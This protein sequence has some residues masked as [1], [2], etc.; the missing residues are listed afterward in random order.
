[1]AIVRIKSKKLAKKIQRCEPANKA[2]VVERKA[3]HALGLPPVRGNTG[4]NP[5]G[6]P[7]VRQALS[8]EKDALGY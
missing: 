7:I 6:E 2:A 3:R 1:V 8:Y 4:S 5:V